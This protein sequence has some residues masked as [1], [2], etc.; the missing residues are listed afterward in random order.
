ML[1]ELVFT[2]EIKKCKYTEWGRH[3]AG[4]TCCYKCIVK[5]EI[6]LS[7]GLHCVH[8]SIHAIHLTHFGFL[9]VIFI[10]L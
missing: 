3:I 6:N 1:K 2:V 9:D 10:K 4:G 5:G 7:D 8:F